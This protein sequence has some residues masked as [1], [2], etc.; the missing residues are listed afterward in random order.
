[1]DDIDGRGRSGPIVGVLRAARNAGFAVDVD[2]E[3]LRVT[4]PQARS[5]ILDEIREHKA[6]IIEAITHPPAGVSH[7]T[8]RMT[9]GVEWLAVCWD[10]LLGGANTEAMADAFAVNLERWYNLDIELRRVY[11]EFR[12]CPVGGCR[13]EAIVSCMHCAALAQARTQP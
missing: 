3:K 11:P 7:Y 9:S 8:E 4:G 1:M 2:G 13:T 6:E 5:D 10:K 12:G